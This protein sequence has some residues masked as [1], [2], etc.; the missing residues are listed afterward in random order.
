MV[1]YDFEVLFAALGL[2]SV[3]MHRAAADELL[4]LDRVFEKVR[5]RMVAALYVKVEQL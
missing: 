2:V 3:A 1:D 4:L 5:E